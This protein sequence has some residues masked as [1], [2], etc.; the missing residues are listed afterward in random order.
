MSPAST[1]LTCTDL[2]LDAY[3][4]ALDPKKLVLLSGGHFAPY[5]DEFE[6]SSSAARD[7]FVTHLGTPPSKG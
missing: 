3:N 2:Q 7:W 5:V 4:R 1:C 6:V